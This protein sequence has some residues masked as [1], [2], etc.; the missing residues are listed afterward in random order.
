MAASVAGFEISSGASLAVIL[1][2]LGGGI[3]L[4]LLADDED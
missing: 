1:A 2:T 3:G 4:S